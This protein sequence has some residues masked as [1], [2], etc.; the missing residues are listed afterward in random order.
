M[1][2][3][4]KVVSFKTPNFLCFSFRHIYSIHYYYL[5]SNYICQDLLSSHSLQTKKINRLILF[6]K[7]QWLYET[8]YI[9]YGVLSAQYAKFTFFIIENNKSHIKILNKSGP[10]VKRFGT[11]RRISSHELYVLWIFFL[12]FIG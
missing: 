4:M 10:K 5:L 12:L 11:P 2:I 1:I 8:I 7:I 3:R 9:T 6:L